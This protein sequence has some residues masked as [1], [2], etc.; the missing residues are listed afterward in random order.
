MPR[1]AF[2][3]SL[4]CQP[5]VEEGGCVCVRA[6]FKSH[7]AFVAMVMYL[8]VAVL[9]DCISFIYMLETIFIS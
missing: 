6:R 7:V 8:R 4:D 1:L 9:Y 5:G 3:A 2:K